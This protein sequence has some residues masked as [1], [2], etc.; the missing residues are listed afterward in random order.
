MSGLTDEQKKVCE[1]AHR[2]ATHSGLNAIYAAVEAFLAMP[3][4]SHEGEKHSYTSTACFHGLHDRCRKTCKFCG[5]GCNCSC[6]HPN[7]PPAKPKTAEERVT[8]KWGM[9]VT[10]DPAMHIQGLV[11]G[12]ATIFSVNGYWVQ[13]A[14]RGQ[15]QEPTRQWE[16]I[17]HTEADKQAT[18]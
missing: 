7:S 16:I 13:T 5:V 8:R 14:I 9:S 10:D 11:D 15:A 6:G 12:G 3:T 4:S 18:R 1:K 2:L 17:W